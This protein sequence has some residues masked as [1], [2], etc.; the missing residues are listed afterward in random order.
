MNYKE[1]DNTD[2]ID[3]LEVFSV[4]LNHK[5]KILFA[6]SIFAIFSVVYSLSI[7]NKY[8]SSSTLQVIQD[9]KTSNIG[10]LS[11]YS[12]LAS[13]AGVSLP[14]SGE[15]KSTLAIATINSRT[16]LQHL[17]SF[18]DVLPNMM[19]A[20]SYDKEENKIIFDETIYDSSKRIWI[21][22]NK[23]QTP[24][25]L[26]AYKV[27]MDMVDISKDDKSNLVYISVTH[28]SPVF[29]DYFLNL[30]IDEVNKLIREKD[31]DESEESIKYFT[32]QL[33]Q[34]NQADIRISINQLLKSQLEIQM[35]S[36]VR[37]EYILR[38]LDP[39]FV[40]I[41]KSYPKRSIICIIITM[42]GFLIS[43]SYFLLNH[44]VIQWKNKSY[45]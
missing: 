8:T 17:L 15:D 34:T 38:T 13:I 12:Q 28:I 26:D 3:L 4:L 29:A 32:D 14:S 27:Y 31:L 45:K 41:E 35:L 7:D 11:R 43:A 33:N 39:P 1:H 22:D 2:E 36:N 40:P 9:D 10:S 24:S 25:Y 6:T 42:L 18:E 37:A 21:N 44:Y 16:F 19:A 30:I 20:K 5:F 23:K